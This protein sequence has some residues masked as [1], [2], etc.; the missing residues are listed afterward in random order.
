M[1]ER[2]VITYKLY[3]SAAQDVLLWQKKVLLKDLWNAALEE[4]IGAWRLARKS[5]SDG[6]QKKAI[7]TIRLD[8]PG[9]LIVLAEQGLAAIT[10]LRWWS[11]TGRSMRAAVPDRHIL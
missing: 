9:W 5:I 1:F 4:R 7:K 11:C 10:R 3:P 8:V 6:A 2:R